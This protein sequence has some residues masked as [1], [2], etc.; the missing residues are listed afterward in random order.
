LN[1]G[2]LLEV[3]AS[4][5]I[6]RRW[7]PLEERT[8]ALWSNVVDVGPVWHALGNAFGL[9]VRD[10][11]SD[12]RLV[13]Y[14]FSVPQSFYISPDEDRHLIRTSLRRLLPEAI[15][16]NRRRG[17]QAEDLIPR[18]RLT[19]TAVSATLARIASDPKLCSYVD[20]RK[21]ASIWHGLDRG[22]RSAHRR[23]HT[24]LMRGIYAGF[25]LERLASRS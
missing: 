18:L 7:T 17:S 2:R 22:S 4:K 25:F 13:D 15:V 5:T 9:E 14:C 19:E 21:M 3:A 6:G 16:A 1:Q 20:C 10:P 23:V 12:V 8:M 11:T 24:T